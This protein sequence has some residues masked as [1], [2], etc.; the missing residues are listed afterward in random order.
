MHDPVRISINWT[1]NVGPNSVGGLKWD[2]GSRITIFWISTFPNT[3]DVSPVIEAEKS[4]LDIDRKGP[5]VI[6]SSNVYKKL[7][8][9]ISY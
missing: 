1:G 5:L 2:C 8:K 6:E 9:I 7:L 3:D 4:R